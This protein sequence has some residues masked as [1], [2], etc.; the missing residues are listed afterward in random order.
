MAQPTNTSNPLASWTV[1]ALIV[2][3]SLV[4]LNWHV[5]NSV[6]DIAPLDVGNRSSIDPVPT[7]AQSP[8]RRE[9]SRL[10]DTEETLKRPLFTPTRRPYDPANNRAPVPTPPEAPQPIQPAPPAPR[11]A[12]Q[13]KLVGFAASPQRGKRALV[14]AANEKVG[15]WLS[16]GDQVAG[17]RLRELS[18]DR[19]V[20]EYDSQRQVLEFEAKPAEIPRAPQPK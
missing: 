1:A 3:L 11:P 5:A 9:S 16:I 2:V 7:R 19:A 18:A 4:T 8:P 20:F 17:W 10:T 13:V 14:R 6:V 15:T 12:L